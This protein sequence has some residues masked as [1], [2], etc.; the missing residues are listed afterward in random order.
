MLVTGGCHVDVFTSIRVSCSHVFGQG[1]PI[2]GL[3]RPCPGHVGTTL[4]ASAEQGPYQIYTGGIIGLAKT[5]EKTQFR[6]VFPHFMTRVL[7]H[8]G[9]KASSYSSTQPRAG[10]VE[11]I[12]DLTYKVLA[13]CGAR[14]TLHTLRG[15]HFSGTIAGP[16]ICAKLL[17]KSMQ[18]V[19]TESQ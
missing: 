10:E 19:T 1:V 15:S 13:R 11:C 7:A 6:I 5:R 16:G 3:G 4:H 12:S 8:A 14:F 17:S 2:Q 18:M 9:F